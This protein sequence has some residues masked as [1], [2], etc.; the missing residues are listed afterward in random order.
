MDLS[1]ILVRI[2]AGL[3][4]ATLAACGGGG[5]GGGGGGTT[6]VVYSGVTSAAAITTTNASTITANVVGSD[7]ASAIIGGIS[8]ESSNVTQNQGTGPA[9]LARR[10][11]RILRDVAVR[12]K[13]GA[14]TQQ[15]APGVLVPV[16]DV[17]ACDFGGSMKITGSIDD[18]TG[19]GTLTVTFVDCVFLVGFTI[20]GPSTWRIDGFDVFNLIPTDLTMSFARLMLRGAG[21]SIDAGGSIRFQEIGNTETITMNLDEIN[22]NTGKMRKTVNLVIDTVILSPTSFN[23]TLT[24]QVYHSDFGYVDVTTVTPF[25]FGTL[26]QL[27]PDSGQILLT[28]APEGGGNRAIRVTALAS[29]PAALPATLV[30]LSLDLDGNGAFEIND[31]RLK[32]TDLGGPVGADLG[33]NE[34]DGMHN[35]WETFYGLD[36]DVDDA[37]GNNDGDGSDNLAEY[38]AGT[39]PNVP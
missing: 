37:A 38:L 12:V 16:N 34:P 4:L 3:M 32:W 10:L 39:N 5:D 22:N 36:P 15:V 13:Q 33:D 27:F 29:P 30:R 25:F 18:V 26:N 1:R 17:L 6:A 19:L 28:G 23:Q 21:L 24:G 35:S 2:T 8:V 20:N 11:G 14:S 31:V 7:D 9:E